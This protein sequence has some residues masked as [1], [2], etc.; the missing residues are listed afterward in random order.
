MD[1]RQLRYFVVLAEEL[2]FRRAAERLGIT[3][4][5]LSVSIQALEQHLGTALFHR[6]Q[7]RVE[8]SRAGHALRGHALAILD[9]AERSVAEIRA[10]ASGEAGRLRIGFAASTFLLPMFPQLIHTFRTRYP[11]V[12]VSLQELSSLG[13]IAALQSRTIDTGILR[14]PQSRPPA[15]VSFTR[16]M[17]ERLVV[18]MH[19]GHALAA[20]ASLKI[21]D[22]KGEGFIFYPRQLGAGIYDQFIGLCSKRSFSPSIVQE[23]RES[24]TILGLAATG[25]GIAVVPAGLQHIPIPNIRFRPLDDDDAVTEVLLA[26]RAGEADACI[27]RFS[28][29]ALSAA[30]AGGGVTPPGT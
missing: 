21:S 2:H 25:L 11:N 13:Q 28:R 4:G 24:S 23:A 30:S 10:M 14:K 9:R 17:R 1:L 16:L 26:Y 3:Q 18:A 6:G 22:L 12:E 8:L 20:E 29:R 5:P 7:R 27:A 15:D 19:S